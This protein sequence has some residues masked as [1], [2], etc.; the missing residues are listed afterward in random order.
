[1]RQLVTIRTISELRPIDGA[2]AIECA[3]VDGWTVV[4]KKGEFL[5][6]TPVVFFEVDC[7]LPQGDPR[8][9][10]LMKSGVRTMD[11][12]TGHRLRTVKLRGQLSQGLV[13]PIAVFPELYDTF[14]ALI[15][16]DLT[17]FFEKH[18]G[19]K[20]WE[21]PIP[22]QLAGQV[23]GDF[24]S[25]IRKTDQERCQ[26]LRY[27]IFEQN[28]G[29][30]YEVTTKLD[31]ASCT[32]YHY[33]GEVGVC[34]RNL[35]LK[36]NEENRDNTLVKLFY[37]TGLHLD[38]P[39]LGNVALQG[40]VMGEGIQG[41][42]EQI[43]GHAFFL[44]DVQDLD[45]RRYYTAT[46]RQYLLGKLSNKVFHVP[47]LH[48]MISLEELGITDTAGLLRFAEGPSLNHPVREGVVFK[49][50]DGQFSFKAI[51]NAFLLKEKD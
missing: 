14:G 1:M 16:N 28:A 4:V 3:Q 27:E 40:E 34:S 7:F 20:K 11:G 41:N 36:I 12:V 50:L 6:G 8:F 44:F 24:P 32:F 17:E 37:Q 9:A 43:K 45:L 13:L 35:E 5:A 47:M 18:V 23:K 19:V 31:G 30:L 21:M 15:P 29:A 2:D 38:L 46:E 48:Q 42:R 26:N 49:R 22:A 25:F 33:N 51:S 10:F 39:K